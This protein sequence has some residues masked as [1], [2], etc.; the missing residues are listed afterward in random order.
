MC[1]IT[2]EIFASL[3]LHQPIDS[4]LLNLN[5]SAID[6]SSIQHTKFKKRNLSF[7][8]RAGWFLIKHK[9]VKPK[10]NRKNDFNFWGLLL[11][12]LLAP[13]GVAIAYIAT[14]NK[15]FRRW[16]VVGCITDLGVAILFL[17][18]IIIVIGAF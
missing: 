12:V 4:S 18:T 9:I 15:S 10:N 14:K 1:L 3:V 17:I 16:S 7:R 5:K 2:Q 8:E 11:G 13:V 6:N